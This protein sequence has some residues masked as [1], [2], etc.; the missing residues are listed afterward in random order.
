[1]SIVGVNNLRSC[2][3]GLGREVVEIS[4]L[5]DDSALTT[6]SV[7]SS[8]KET[9][10]LPDS[11]ISSDSVLIQQLLEDKAPLRQ[12]VCDDA[13][14]WLESFAD[15]SL[16]GCVFTSLPDISEVP[17]VAKGVSFLF[18]KV[19]MWQFLFSQLQQKDLM[20]CQHFGA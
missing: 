1:M 15:D 9:N 5:S 13:L 19:S 8:A 17:E 16:P 20:E 18:Q 12:L 2:G 6:P 14:T 11:S 4:E 7:P 3:R 10:C